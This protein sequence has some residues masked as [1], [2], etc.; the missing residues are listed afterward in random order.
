M[1]DGNEVR[2]SRAASRTLAERLPLAAAAAIWE[3]L[4]GP[5]AEDPR[6][7]GKPLSGD[8]AG[9]QSARRGAYRVV[10]SITEDLR[11]ISVVRIDHRRNVYRR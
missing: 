10:Y 9:Y 5:L 7:L 6:R 8:L 4:T 3:F 1:S 11:L 2:L